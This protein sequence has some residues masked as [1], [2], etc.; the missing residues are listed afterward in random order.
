MSIPHSR[1]VVTPVTAFLTGAALALL[2][3]ASPAE[4]PTDIKGA[5]QA[6]VAGANAGT[7]VTLPTTTTDTIT[8]RLMA[9]AAD[10]DASAALPV[11]LEA[12]G[13]S[14]RG[15]PKAYRFRT[16]GMTPVQP[17]A[18]W[19]P[20]QSIGYRVNLANSTAGALSDVKGAIARVSSATGLRFVY[21]GTTKI[22]PGR[23]NARYPADTGLVIA[24]A[25]PGQSTHLPKGK[26]G[27]AG[28]G[29]MTWA[30][31]RDTKG[32]RAGMITQA[33]VVLNSTMKYAR[34]F[35]SGP[36][37]GWQGTR[38]QLLMHEV[39][40][41]V[42]LDHPRIKDKYAILSPVITRRPAVWGAGDMNGFRLVGKSAGCLSR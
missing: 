34:G 8:Y 18:R 11:G 36:S 15:N 9:Q 17:I 37:T 14:Y 12:T 30:Y 21:R 23:G 32:R 22:L 19:N 16:S 39:A 33:S 10:S 27:V 3:V 7:S 1:H 20:C 26:S 42:G 35:G 13:Q 6:S 31:A 5:H 41:A 40:H 2:S 25:K 38:G 28:M 24:W 4:A 29:H